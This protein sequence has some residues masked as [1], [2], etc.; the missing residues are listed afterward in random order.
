VK[1]PEHPLAKLAFSLITSDRSGAVSLSDA[2]AHRIGDALLAYDDANLREA[3]RQ[4]AV[5][6]GLVMTKLS[7]PNAKA[8][9][10]RILSIAELALDR[11]KKIDRAQ[12]TEVERSRAFVAGRIGA[13]LYTKT[14]ARIDSVRPEGTV[15]AASLAGPAGQRFI[16]SRSRE[17]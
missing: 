9:G 11:L 3:T 17:R 12:A 13:S 2:N 7:K 14:A 6:G 4:L 5:V 1:A 16:R 8:V 15:T 10:D